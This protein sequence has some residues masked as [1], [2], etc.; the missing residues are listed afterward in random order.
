MSKPAN[1]SKPWTTQ[2]VGKLREL[3]IGNTPTRLAAL[4]L[5]RTESSVRSEAVKEGISLKPTN[6][7]PYN[8]RKG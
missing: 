8:R 1:H 7:A 2:D 5:G 4:K 6:Q 3:A